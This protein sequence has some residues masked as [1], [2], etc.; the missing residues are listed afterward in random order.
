[1]N[2]VL[3]LGSGG[4]RFVVARQLR[5]SGGMWFRFGETQI[6]VDPGPGAL[7]RALSHVPPCNPRELAAIALSHKHLDHAGDVNALIEAMTSG[8]FHRRGALLAPADALDD[9]PT[10]FPYAQHFVERLERVVANGG[11]YRIGD[12]EMRPSITHIH[13]VETY[14]MHFQHN[15]LRVSYLPCGRYFDALAED[16][17]AAQPD[18]LIL[19]VLLFRDGMDVDHLTWEQARRVVERVRP[20]VAIFQHFGTRMLEQEPHKLAQE[21]EDALGLRAIAAYDG[22]EVDLDTEVAAVVA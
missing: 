9:E 13:A 15:G 20:R 21:V 8:G 14:G 10:V 11:P 6:H 17:A 4:A 5:A 3:F 19:N 18:V 2:S 1:M 12:V 16:Y 22:L 7:V